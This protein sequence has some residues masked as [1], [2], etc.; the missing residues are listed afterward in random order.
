MLSDCGQ[1]DFHKNI[2]SLLAEYGDVPIK[3]IAVYR[4]PV[5]K[6][7]NRL[8]NFF[9]LGNWERI[10][11]YDKYYHLFIGITL[12]NDRV[13]IL[14]KETM[15]IT[16]RGLN[17]SAETETKLVRVRARKLTINIMIDRTIDAIGRCSFFQYDFLSTNCQHFVKSI[18][19]SNHLLTD[20]LTD[21]IHQ[22]TEY[23]VTNLPPFARRIM[24]ALGKMSTRYRKFTGRGKVL[25]HSMID[26]VDETL[27]PLL[28]EIIS[29]ERSMHAK[30]R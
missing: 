17:I 21:F 11:Q 7:Y 26:N 18:L 15:I 29:L 22:P 4:L 12:Q 5:R 24:I 9:T 13:V 28:L 20:E 6:V 25:P 23:L 2:K 30:I 19:A 27:D 1:L 14:E 10:K 3:S 16:R 8:L